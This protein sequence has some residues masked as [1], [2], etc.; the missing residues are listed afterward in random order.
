MAVLLPGRM[1]L[2]RRRRSTVL[3]KSIKSSDTVVTRLPAVAS[4]VGRFTEQT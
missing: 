4:S 1:Y 2:T 3:N